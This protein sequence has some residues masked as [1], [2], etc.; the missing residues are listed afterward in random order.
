MRGA[1]AKLALARVEA[2]DQERQREEA[3]KLAL[4]RVRHVSNTLATH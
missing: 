1:G 3:A 4:E 2:L